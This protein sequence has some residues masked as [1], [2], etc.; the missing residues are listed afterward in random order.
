[1]D[2]HNTHIMVTDDNHPVRREKSWV[3]HSICPARFSCETYSHE[4]STAACCFCSFVKSLLLSVAFFC[5]LSPRLR[6]FTSFSHSCAL[7][8]LF[9]RGMNRCYTVTLYFSL[10]LYVIMNDAQTTLSI[11]YRLTP[12]LHSMERMKMSCSSP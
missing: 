2:C 10:Y 3:I 8:S 12:S 7:F 6:L 1:M 4:F 5:L 11:L 9:I